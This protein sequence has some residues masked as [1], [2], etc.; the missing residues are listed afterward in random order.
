[1][2]N[3]INFSSKIALLVEDNEMNVMLFSIFLRRL[4]IQFKVATN[5]EDA[6]TLIDNHHFDIILTDIHL[7][8]L[9]GDEMARIIRKLPDTL[10]ANTPIVA[11][12]ASVETPD[13]GE[14]IFAGINEV[15]QKPFAEQQLVDILIKYLCET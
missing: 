9:W 12:T 1:M 5:A 6:L 8:K 11:L 10:K 14:Y 2:T 15:L 13:L 4:S 3:S 7:P